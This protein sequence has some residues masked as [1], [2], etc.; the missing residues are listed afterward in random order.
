MR[1]IIIETK[2][3]AYIGYAR[4]LF[5]T[6]VQNSHN[7]YM[8]KQYTYPIITSQTIKVVYM[9]TPPPPPP[10][11]PHTHTQEFIIK[12]PIQRILIIATSRIDN[13]ETP[14]T[15]DTQIRIGDM[16]KTYG[17]TEFNSCFGWLNMV[18]NTSFNNMSAISWQS[19]AVLLVEETG[20]PG[21]NHR[22]VASY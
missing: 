21:D 14:A 4:F 18:F 19:A 7:L 2:E 1:Y 9:L 5:N 22:P 6:R 13:P 8:T 10:P 12:L 17:S 11:P 16:K 20:V 15:L 3:S